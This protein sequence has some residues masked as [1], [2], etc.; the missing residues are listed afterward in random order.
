[1]APK[2]KRL[3]REELLQK[4]REAERLRYETRKN[5]PQKRE[6]MREKE[7]LKYQKKKEKGLRKLVKDMTPRE[8][9]AT[10]KKWREHC[11]NYR[12]KRLRLKRIADT[13]VRENTPLS[14]P[15]VNT[16]L[17]SPV[18]ICL[19]PSP[20]VSS[21]SHQQRKK[22]GEMRRKKYNR[23]RNEK[24]AC[25]E[26]QV[27]KYKKRLARIEKKYK[28]HVEDTPKTKILKMLDEPN[29]RKEVVTKALFS[30]VISKQLKDNYSTLKR[31][32]EKQIFK[33]VVTGNVIR[34][35]KHWIPK[36]MELFS[37]PGKKSNFIGLEVPV[38]KRCCSEKMGGACYGEYASI[39]P[40]LCTMGSRSPVT[41]RSVEF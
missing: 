30:D 3:S 12:T 27:A 33:N 5:D 13:F 29:Q 40:R 2:K 31:T 39:G 36:E 35:Y 19:A 14:D 22:E 16:P 34:K 4:K 7:K 25:L 38:A 17:V 28:K 10:L 9:R 41:F 11:S 37:R 21:A 24:I 18:P 6:E 20:A 32:K 15:E 23:E 8:H 26:K 1:M